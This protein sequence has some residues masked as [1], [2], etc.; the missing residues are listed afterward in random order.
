MDPC[1]RRRSWLDGVYA[2]AWLDQGYTINTLS[3]RNRSNG[4]VTFNDRSNDYELNQMYLR[5]SRDVGQ[6]GDRWDI[7]W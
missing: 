1:Q 6:D 3:P 4:P 5:L 2:D 7:G